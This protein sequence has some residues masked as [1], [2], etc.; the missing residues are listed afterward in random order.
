M[1]ADFVNA[2]PDYTYEIEPY[3]A[4]RESVEIKFA[5]ESTQHCADVQ[6]DYL[7]ERMQ[8]YA[9]GGKAVFD[10]CLI[11]LLPYCQYTARFGQTDIDQNYLQVLAERI[12]EH[13]GRLDLIVFLPITDKHQVQLEDDKIRPTD[14]DYRAEVDEN[15]KAVYRQGAYGMLSRADAPKVVELWGPRAERVNKLE[16]IIAEMAA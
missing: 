8:S 5:K 10:R 1:V 12:R 14:I 6:V 11:D 2:H 4:L 15:F 16:T 3:R 9:G 7:I 13:V